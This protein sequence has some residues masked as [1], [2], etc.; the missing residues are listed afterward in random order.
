MLW[1]SVSRPSAVKGYTL[2]LYLS[3]NALSC[4][5]LVV[6]NG[7]YFRL[8][9]QDQADQGRDEIQGLRAVMR[10]ISSLQLYE[11]ILERLY[12]SLHRQQG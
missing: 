8:L 11:V 4:A 6:I 5:R 3:A 9:L 1:R 7:P 10:F 12:R 2:G